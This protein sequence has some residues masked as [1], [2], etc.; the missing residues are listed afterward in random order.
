[1][2]SK[3]RR[4]YPSNAEFDDEYTTRNIE[5]KNQSEKYGKRNERER[6]RVLIDK[7]DF[8]C[9]QCGAFVSASRELSG[10]NNRNHC[11][12]CLWSLHVDLRVA[13]DRKA[14]CGSRMEPVG[15]TV[16]R[17]VKRYSRSEPGELMLI[18]RCTGCQK[19]SINRIAADDD[20]Q[21]LFKLF[22]DSFEIQLE[23]GQEENIRLLNEGDFPLVY[24][25]LFG[26]SQFIQDD[27]LH[28]E[29]LRQIQIIGTYGTEKGEPTSGLE[30]DLR[31][32][33]Y[34]E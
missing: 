25:R 26:V 33:E 32:A 24:T 21:A 11:P 27:N 3:H 12:Q 1:V 13:G 17:V 28:V 5:K 20:V 31:I 8:K 23:P 34:R 16:K 29:S 4:K 30:S 14:D 10:V 7:Q 19:L 6:H 2:K 15:L 18:H 22:L 9:R